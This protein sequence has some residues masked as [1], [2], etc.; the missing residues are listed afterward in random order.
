MIF[1]GLA[2]YVLVIFF[3]CVDCLRQRALSGTAKV[4]FVLAL[5]LVPVLGILGYGIW[6]MRHSRGL[7]EY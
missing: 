4:L 3:L 1:F 7:P 5:V 2:I 6:R